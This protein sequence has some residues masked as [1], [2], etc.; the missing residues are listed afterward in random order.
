[1]FLTFSA[2]KLSICLPT[3]TILKLASVYP[4]K[5]ACY[6]LEKDRH[7][8]DIDRKKKLVLLIHPSIQ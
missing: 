1:M 3:C 2:W 6:C 5:R 4:L 8:I 7:R